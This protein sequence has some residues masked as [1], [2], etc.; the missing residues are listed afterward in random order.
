MPPK[1]AAPAAKPA[2]KA[3]AK[4]P[5]PKAAAPV[6]AAAPAAKTAA[7]AAAAP[8]VEKKAVAAGSSNGVY[9]KNWGQGSVA[10]AT[11]AFAAAGKV[12]RAQIRRGK[13]ALVFFENAAS[14]KK[15]V[16]S[17]NGKEVCGATVNVAPAKTSPKADSHDATSVVFVGPIFRESTTRKQI[18]DLFAGSKIVKLRTYRQNYAYLYFDSAAAAQKAIKEKNGTEFKGKTLTV[19]ASTRSLEAE[20]KRNEHNK[21][22]IE[23]HNWKK[24]QSH[25]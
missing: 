4:A 3:A 5:A 14:V 22:L 1:A 6:K 16:D 24:Q 15:A 13:Y 17:F 18:F 9:V 11:A 20:K 25:H 10:D 12:T 8:K 7:P 2:A 19:K 21:T 23:V